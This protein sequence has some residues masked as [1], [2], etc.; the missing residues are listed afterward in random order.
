M[1]PRKPVPQYAS[2]SAAGPY[3]ADTFDNANSKQQGIILQE[4]VPTAESSYRDQHASGDT[5]TFL[6]ATSAHRPRLNGFR[7]NKTKARVSILRVFGAWWLELL[8]CALAVAGLMTIIGIL[9]PHQNLPLPRLPY[10]LTIN[11][12]VSICIVVIKAAVLLIVAQGK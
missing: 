11:S 5:S 9:Y 7:S 8:A 10:K 6:N 12:L 2:L 1:I 4:W 3:Q